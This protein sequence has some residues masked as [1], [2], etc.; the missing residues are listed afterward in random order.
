MLA[1]HLTLPSLC[2]RLSPP[3]WQ[4]GSPARARELYAS[5]L[6]APGCP[7]GF[8]ALLL[9]NTAA[10]LQKEGDVLQA[11]AV[12]TRACALNPAFRKPY[13]RLASMLLELGMSDHSAKVLEKMKVRQGPSAVLLLPTIYPFL[14][15]SMYPSIFLSFFL[16]VCPAP[17]M[18]IL[19]YRS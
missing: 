7:A 14:S 15:V 6:S 11:I 17:P 5:A 19:C 2:T 18:S 10:T 4:A 13:S 8:V 12:C 1:W 3:S 16:S 9:S